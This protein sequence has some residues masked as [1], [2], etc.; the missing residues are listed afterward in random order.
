MSEKQTYEGLPNGWATSNLGDLKES[1]LYGPRFSSDL[2]ADSGQLVLRTSDVSES[3]KVNVSTAPKIQLDEDSF[4]K[5]SLKVGDLMV[6]RTGS[7]GTVAVFDDQVDAIPG[8]YLIRYRLLVSELAPFIFH[9]LRS[10]RAQRLLRRGAGGVGRPNLNAPTIERIDIPIAPL[11]EQTRIVE[12]IESYFTRLDKAVATLERVQANL[13][14]YRASV[15]KAAVEGRLVPTEAELARQ[16][17]RDLPAPR[18]HCFFVYAIECDDGSHYTGQTDDL[19]RRWSEHLA[20]SAADWTK[21]HHPRR[22]AHYEKHKTREEAVKRE[23]ELK[24][25]YG[26]K[27]LKREIAA[28]RTRQ[29]GYEPASVLLERILKERR[30]RWEEAELAALK[31]KGKEPKNDKW[32]AKYKEPAAPDTSELPDLPEGWCWGTVEALC[33]SVSDGD[34]QPPPQVDDGI[35]FLVI[36]NVRSG[37]LTF[38]GCR[39]VPRDYFN[40]IDSIRR[41]QRG[42]VLYSVTGSFG[43]P[44]LVDTD[45]D[46]C[47]QRHIAILRPCS[48]IDTSLL[49]QF[50]SSSFV[51]SQAAKVA[52]GTAQ[53][54]VPLKGLRAIAIPIPPIHEQARIATELDRLFSVRAD[55]SSAIS[56]N[57]ARCSRLRQSILKWAFEGKLADQD[58]NDE[59]ASALLDRIMAEREA[60]AAKTKTKPKTRKK[61]TSRKRS[62]A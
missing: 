13:K 44:V 3:G 2:Y 40:Q 18:P 30:R 6:T 37:Q 53:K 50:L 52:T 8:A 59:P 43:I 36:G 28:G 22:I 32:K 19:R 55:A 57:R 23:K 39:F 61:R 38:E 41:P 60:T 54:T 25:G 26:R 31:A 62:A 5:Y 21:K 45:R 56:T 4:R 49:V 46:F 24:T 14:R 7:I 15:L 16:E 20:G 1:S 9:F 33:T 27:W 34:H 58:P 12:A 47:V 51:F 29:A 17:G 11:P 48:S 10:N 42:D 35:P